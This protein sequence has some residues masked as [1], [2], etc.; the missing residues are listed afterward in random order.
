MRVGDVM[1]RDVEFVDTA[2]SVAEAASIMGDLSVGALPV[3]TADDL[4]GILTDRD[5]LF[6]VVATGL[7]NTDVQVGDVM[8]TTIF[9]CREEDAITVALD[10]M[11]ARNVRRLPVLDANGRVVGLVTLSDLSRR[12]LLDSDLIKQAVYEVSGTTPG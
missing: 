4:Q 7:S 3:G 12:M 6:R 2:A 9:S 8:T 1:A 5:I 10:L 11:G